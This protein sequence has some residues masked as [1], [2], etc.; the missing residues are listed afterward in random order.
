M[1]IFFGVALVLLAG[2]QVYR[3]R[4]SSMDDMQRT[5]TVS[6]T[7]KPVYFWLLIFVEVLLGIL[8]LLGVFHVGA[9]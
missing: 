3:G 1:N 4:I 8:F 5:S 6:R 9:G 7:T 2:Y